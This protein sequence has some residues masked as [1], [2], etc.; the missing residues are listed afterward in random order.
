ML[1]ETV[2]LEGVSRDSLY[3]PQKEESLASQRKKLEDS[4]RMLL[5]DLSVSRICYFI[6]VLIDRH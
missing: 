2:P 4:G 5:E 1:L 6:V 3:S